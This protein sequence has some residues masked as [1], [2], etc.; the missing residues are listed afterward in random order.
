MLKATT[1]ESQMQ[2][3]KLASRSFMGE[4]VLLQHPNIAVGLVQQKPDQR[5][6]NIPIQG[7]HCIPSTGRTGMNVNFVDTD[8]SVHAHSEISNRIN[9]GK[10]TEFM[11]PVVQSN[12]SGTG[13][14]NVNLLVNS[15]QVRISMNSQ[16]SEPSGPGRPGSEV[17]GGGCGGRLQDI[18]KNPPQQ[19][20]CSHLE[21]YQMDPNKVRT[22]YVPATQVM[23]NNFR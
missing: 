13:S 10:I 6:P 1:E 20:Y 12:Y 7:L 9:P 2:A 11:Q 8:N 5:P 18:N 21:K 4:T 15:D 14:Q 23:M 22:P 17:I 3:K 16:P 19:M